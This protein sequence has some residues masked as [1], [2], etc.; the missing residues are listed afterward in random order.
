MNLQDFACKCSD[1]IW[2]GE[3][4]W[5]RPGGLEELYKVIKKYVRKDQD[6][7]NDPNI[8]S[9]IKINQKQYEYKIIDGESKKC[10]NKLNELKKDYYR[11]IISMESVSV[12][13]VTILLTIKP[14]K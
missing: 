6:K 7:K 3:L 11:N 13:Y 8:G 12:N 10:E 9:P 4:G 1:L 5:D 14:K 2:G